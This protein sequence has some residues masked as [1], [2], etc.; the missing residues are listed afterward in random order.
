MC[1]VHEH[2]YETLPYYSLCI[3]RLDFLRCT[4]L[5]DKCGSLI[6][7]EN[8][9]RSGKVDSRMQFSDLYSS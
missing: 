1:S 2:V 3:F 7:T 8:D 9:Q 6:G 5:G 4:I